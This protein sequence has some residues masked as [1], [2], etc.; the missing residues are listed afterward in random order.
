MYVYPICYNA[1]DVKILPSIV[2][3]ANVLTV[4]ACRT[5]EQLQAT[6]QGQFC[7]LSYS[8]VKKAK[9]N[10]LPVCL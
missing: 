6:S 8:D 2:T 4:S 9:D 3:Y 10:G 5:N 1:F 7:V